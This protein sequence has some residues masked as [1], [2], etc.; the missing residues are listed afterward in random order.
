[1]SGLKDIDYEIDPNNKNII[2]I[3]PISLLSQEIQ[4]VNITGTAGIY[5]ETV[6]LTKLLEGGDGISVVVD[7][8]SDVLSADENGR[9]FQADI[10]NAKGKFILYKG[11]KNLTENQL[12]S[13]RIDN[14]L[15]ITIEI[16]EVTGE[17]QLLEYS[18]AD[19]FLRGGATLIARYDN[20]DYEF[21]Y[22]VVKAVKGDKGD[23]G[24]QGV[25]GDDGTSPYLG[26][27]ND[28]N[29][30]IDTVNN[31]NV[32]NISPSSL[33]EPFIKN[34]ITYYPLLSAIG[35]FSLLLGNETVED[36]LI[37][38]DLGTENI[39]VQD[40]NGLFFEINDDGSYRAFVKTDIVQSEDGWLEESQFETFALRAITEGVVRSTKTIKIQ[41]TKIGKD[42]KTG[43]S[44]K[45]QISPQFFRF[46]GEGEPVDENEQ[47]QIKAIP[48]NVSENYPGFDL[49]LDTSPENLQLQNIVTDPQTKIIT[50]TLPILSFKDPN[51][52]EFYNTAIITAVVS[53]TE[54]VDGQSVTTDVLEDPVTIARTQSGANAKSIVLTSDSFAFPFKNSSIK[55]E[56]DSIN[57]T[58]KT[59]NLVTPLTYED[60]IITKFNG[61]IVDKPASSI[62]GPDDEGNYSFQIFLD[63]EDSTKISLDVK[64]KPDKAETFPITIRARQEDIFDLI[65]IIRVE[66]K[67]GFSGYLTNEVD[68]IPATADGTDIGDYST[69]NGYFEVFLG[70]N[71]LS[72]EDGVRFSVEDQTDPDMEV[73][74]NE[75]TGYYYVSTDP[76]I[77]QGA[78]T[79]RRFL[80][81]TYTDPET[82]EEQTL[83]KIFTV[84]KSKQGENT[85]NAILS[86]ESHTIRANSDGSLISQTRA[87]DLQKA[88]GSIKVFDGNEDRTAFATFKVLQG[89]EDADPADAGNDNSGEYIDG[90]LKFTIFSNG[91][92]QLSTTS[93]TSWN[94]DSE[95]FYIKIEYNGEE[96]IKRYTITKS[97]GGA[98]AKILTLQSDRQVFTFDS[99]NFANPA[100]QKITFTAILNNIDSEVVWSAGQYTHLLKTLDGENP[101]NNVRVLTIDDFRTEDLVSLAITATADTSYSDTITVIKTKDGAAGSDSKTVKITSTTNVIM[102]P[103]EESQVPEQKN[104]NIFIDG[105]NLETEIDSSK[106]SMKDASGQSIR[107]FDSQDDP[108]Y[109]AGDIYLQTD[110]TDPAN[111][112][113]F[114]ISIQ[115]GKEDTNYNVSKSQFPIEVSVSVDGVSDFYTIHSLNGGTNTINLLVSN[116]SHVVPADPDGDV[117]EIGLADAGGLLELY[118]GTTK[119][120]NPPGTTDLVKF[121]IKVPEGKTVVEQNLESSL[122]LNGLVMTV[123]QETGVYELSENP[124]PSITWT[125][126]SE[127]FEFSVEFDGKTFNK[128]YSISKSKEGVAGVNGKDGK[129]VALES[130]KYFIPYKE[131]SALETF[132]TLT[133]TPYNTKNGSTLRYDFLKG[134]SDIAD[135]DNYDIEN[136]KLTVRSL[137]TPG[138]T[139]TYFVNLF[140]DN[141]QVAQDSVS[142]VATKEGSDAITVSIPNDNHT[143]TAEP[144][145]SVITTDGSGTEIK[146]LVGNTILNALEDTVQDEDMEPGSFK[147]TVAGSEGI[148]PGDILRSDPVDSSDPNTL[149]KSLTLQNVIMN[150][151]TNNGI[152]TFTITVLKP[153]A[154]TPTVITRVASYSKSVK[155]TDGLNARALF[156]L[157]DSENF[158]L[159][160]AGNIINNEINFSVIK[161]NINSSTVSITSSPP[162]IL[163][164]INSVAGTAKLTF[165]SF[166]EN[167]SVIVS[168]SATDTTDNTTFSDS[169]TINKIES[170]KDGSNGTDSKIVKLESNDYQISYDEDGKNPDPSSVT[171]TATQ[172][173][174]AGTVYYR[175][176]K[177][178]SEIQNTTSN[179]AT[180][181]LPENKFNSPISLKVETREVD[182][183]E[184]PIDLVIATD[185][186]TIIGTKDGSNSYSISIPNENHT[187]VA[188]ENG[189]ITSTDYQGGNTFIEAYIGNT[190][191]SPIPGNGDFTDNNQFKVQLLNASN[192]TLGNLAPVENEPKYLLSQLSNMTSDSANITVAITV[193]GAT[194]TTQTFNKVLSYSKSRKGADG[195]AIAGY[196]TNESHTVTAN[197]DG[198]EYDLADAGGVFEVF[199]GSQKLTQGVSYSVVGAAEA[200]PN[201]DS[202]LGLT[203]TINETEGTYSLSGESWSS[204]RA[205]FTLRA[206]YDVDGVPVNIDKKYSISKSKAA[207]PSISG[208]LTNETHTV[209]AAYD[210][211]YTSLGTAGGTFEIFEGQQKA[212]GFSFT[213]DS[214]TKN[215]LTATINPITGIYSFSGADWD[216][217]S[218]SFIFTAIKG[219]G[220]SAITIQKTYTI[221]KSKGGVNGEPAKA[222]FLYSD[223][224]AFIKNGDGQFSPLGL[225]QT[226]NFEAS[227]QNVDSDTLVWKVDD[228]EDIVDTLTV[229]EDKLSA[230]MDN[231][232]FVAGVD[233]NINSRKVT[234]SSGVFSDSI[235]V[236]ATKDGAAAKALFLKSDKQSFRYDGSDADFYAGQVITF[237]ADLKNITGDVT[238]KLFKDG[239]GSDI[240]DK[241]TAVTGQTYQKQLTVAKYKEAIGNDGTSVKVRI[242]TVHQHL[243]VPS[244][245]FYLLNRL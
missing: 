108:E 100:G 21:Q 72:S 92:Y 14:P 212:T 107:I 44:L 89:A 13:Y 205:V 172:Q 161:E 54:T 61:E 189:V 88:G 200:T 111:D 125:S 213:V 40:K 45:L 221:T 63:S 218:T 24:D 67:D 225:V 129:T 136:N 91:N 177:D 31:D 10:L 201:S 170:G 68:Q 162:N 169:I 94:T 139:D 97:K 115:D 51:T 8:P 116:E 173:N 6:T 9:V 184:Q 79:A 197:A 128:K 55:S 3:Y 143:F 217:D 2:R 39:K 175:F 7:N 121:T 226:I 56:I 142:I 194:E 49:R 134:T 105:Q 64:N 75:T 60:I 158:V 71:K 36:S 199:F 219:S 58:V 18:G 241:L 157:S 193:R 113:F 233:L 96:I 101:P 242:E 159:N 25:K 73:I 141:I 33:G 187:F 245:L 28:E 165:S 130:D 43:P 211:T 120:V 35:T 93:T 32:A 98:D 86:N 62:S 152:I 82:G 81:A 133:A 243:L 145:G 180:I 244:S 46:N 202:D 74:I 191:L 151:D 109:S 227:P 84:V 240:S 182:E 135:D 228:D 118:E 30:F 69:L 103:T 146:V 27:I 11:T 34:D 20:T 59:Q 126:L 22:S 102:Y 196:L 185:S 99:D 131:D 76:K 149:Y 16:D 192:I 215:N 119:L 166:G 70:T 153:N 235:T 50:A 4:A 66:G 41:K 154:S 65:K 124:D 138:N 190:Q 223:K 236:I 179:T 181:S 167:S 214:N 52:N 222:V 29:V 95:V 38:F 156:L 47:L 206:T 237:T 48:L 174:H 5:S 1:M 87:S 112:K 80:L 148:T 231:E 147:I 127:V 150:Q 188:D 224:Q 140:E 160:K 90:G 114:T 230:T 132:F 12:V 123:N 78:D 15:N 19:E 220:A 83:T 77:K 176:I 106:I 203:I 104:I 163:T 229:S 207:R 17:Y 53:T 208:Y 155:G 186:I 183:E 37:T 110:S 195:T 144:N 26:I 42:G 232:Q 204:D 137:P 209:L 178:E 23:T 210:G 216:A 117:D 171:I 198:Y 85:F 57:I 168:V 234:V 238:W 164:S 239:E 122:E